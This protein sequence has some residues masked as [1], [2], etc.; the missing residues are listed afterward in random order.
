MNKVSAFKEF[1]LALINFIA[2]HVI[3]D[4]KIDRSAK[5]YW[6]ERKKCSSTISAK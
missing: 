2:Y 5:S 1:V 3:S 6:I 4:N